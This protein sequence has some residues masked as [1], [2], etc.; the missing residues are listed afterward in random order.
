MKF[1][2]GK[3][4][5]ADQILSDQRK[6]R[7]NLRKKYRDMFKIKFSIDME[8]AYQEIKQQIEINT[9]NEWPITPNVDMITYREM[10]QESLSKKERDDTFLNLYQ[11]KEINLIVREWEQIIA[12]AFKGWK[13]LLIEAKNVY[14]DGNYKVVIPLLFSYLEAFMNY[15]IGEDSKDVSAKLVKQFTNKYKEEHKLKMDYYMLESNEILLTEVIFKRG[16]FGKKK[17]VFNR[18]CVLHGRYDPKEWKEIHAIKLIVILS[19]L[20]FIQNV[21]KD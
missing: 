10:G 8:K 7:E 21:H 1:S 4:N 3:I 15:Y 17:P 13:E 18:H 6:F 5:I 14:L 20:T 19:S 11:N 2:F 16:D 9:Q 12:H